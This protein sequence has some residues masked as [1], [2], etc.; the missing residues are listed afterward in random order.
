MSEYRR[1]PAEEE[2]EPEAS[3]PLLHHDEAYLE[4][5]ASGTLLSSIANMCNTI[6]GTGKDLQRLFQSHPTN[7]T[8]Y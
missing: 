8:C 2:L 5:K 1:A 7:Q 4:D 3:S 6:L